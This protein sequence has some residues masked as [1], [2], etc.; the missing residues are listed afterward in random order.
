MTNSATI[1][2]TMTTNLKN[3]LTKLLPTTA[4]TATIDS[5]P[6]SDQQSIAR[7]LNKR[8][9]DNGWQS[10]ITYCSTSVARSIIRQILHHKWKNETSK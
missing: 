4:D 6:E 7:A 3:T 5:I 1:P 10:L 9:H 8:A 2:K